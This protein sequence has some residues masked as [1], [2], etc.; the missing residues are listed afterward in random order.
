MIPPGNVN[1]WRQ[2]IEKMLDDELASPFLAERLPTF[3]ETA[4]GLEEFIKRCYYILKISKKSCNVN[5]Y[6]DKAN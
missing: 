1:A 3:E 4:V 6:V 5:L 2:A